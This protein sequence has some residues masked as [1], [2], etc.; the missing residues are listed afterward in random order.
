VKYQYIELLFRPGAD[1]AE[2]SKS[3]EP[4]ALEINGIYLVPSPH[5]PPIYLYI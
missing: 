3:L 2:R 5:H 4:G 1:K